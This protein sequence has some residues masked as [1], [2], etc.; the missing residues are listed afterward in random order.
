[1]TLPKPL[2]RRIDRLRGE[3]YAY[4]V[5]YVAWWLEWGRLPVV[6]H[7]VTEDGKA[8]GPVRAAKIAAFIRQAVC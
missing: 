2:A 1:M 7:Y 4:A 5:D 6:D 3:S 8:L